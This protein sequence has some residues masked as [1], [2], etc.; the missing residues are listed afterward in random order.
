MKPFIHAHS[1]QSHGFYMCGDVYM[2]EISEECRRATH[3]DVFC[4]WEA[5]SVVVV[6]VVLRIRT[7]KWTF[8]SE[9]RCS[10]S[11]MEEWCIFIRPHC[12]TRCTS[13]CALESATNFSLKHFRLSHCMQC[14]VSS[15][16]KKH[17][18]TRY[19]YRKWKMGLCF[20]PYFTVYHTESQFWNLPHTGRSRLHRCKYHFSL[21]TDIFSVPVYCYMLV[22]WLE[23]KNSPTVNHV[24]RKRRLKWVPSDQGYNWVTL[25][26]GDINTQA[27]SS[28]IGVGCG[29]NN[30]TL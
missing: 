7:L 25:P 23:N 27:W 13:M 29:A 22:W 26:L 12:R 24:C 20:H 14:H 16:R 28:R 1:F 18:R 3:I 10:S 6:V 17:C 8:F 15:T 21:H 9:L 2:S 11:Y 19:K 30:P 4:W 5:V